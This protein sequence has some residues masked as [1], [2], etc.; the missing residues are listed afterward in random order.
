VREPSRQEDFALLIDLFRGLGEW[1]AMD[2]LA[3]FLLAAL[4]AVAELVARYKDNPSRALLTGAAAGYVALNGVIGAIALYL[5]M[6]FAPD[7][8]GYEGCAVAEPPAGCE[9]A[10]LSMVLAA[11]FG[12][13]A[14]MRSAFARVTIQGEELGVGP[15]AIIE[16]LQRALDR[17]VD[18]QRAFRRMDE[19]PPSLRDMPLDIVNTTLP[20]LCVE[21][22][23]NLSAEEKQALDQRLTL[24]P[25][26]KVHE[27]MRPLVVALILQEYV[28]KDVLVRAVDKILTDYKD[29]L[30]EIAA[31]RSSAAA[32]AGEGAFG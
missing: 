1:V 12:S 28:G 11:G 31:A 18:R 2:Y 16:I 26:L 10:L 22:M 29:V 25:E 19:L 7:L 6:V 32:L 3:V 4:V 9:K 15:S 17:E 23:Q 24:V 8:F 14:V 27:K 30:D 13:L 21:L 20:V 5:L